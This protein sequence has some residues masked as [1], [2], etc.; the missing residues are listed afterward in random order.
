MHRKR[1]TV[2]TLALAAIFALP[3]GLAV[4][5]VA[6][7]DPTAI[8]QTIP[9]D[10]T[11][12]LVVRNLTELD[13]KIVAFSEKVGFPLGTPNSPFPRPLQ[14]IKDSMG[15]SEGIDD[16]GS[17]AI[18]VL[19]CTNA[20]STDE[21][22]GRLAVFIPTTDAKA[23]VDAL[24]G[25][26][27][28]DV[29]KLT[30]AGEPSVAA[31]ANNF[32]VV[33]Q[34]AETL[35]EALAVKG[36]VAQAMSPSRLDAYK[37]NDLT[38]WVNARGISQEIRQEVSTALMGVMAMGNPQL[39]GGAQ[40][41]NTVDQMNK[42]C[43]EASEF[44]AALTLDTQK[45]II[46][47]GYYALKPDSEY[48][49]QMA[50][51][52]TPQGPLLIGLPSEPTIVAFGSVGGGGNALYEK[53]MRQSFDQILNEQTL[54]AFVEAEKLQQIKD[55]LVNV[56]ISVETMSFG[57]S[58]LPAE[59]GQGMIGAT[60]VARVTNGEK[61]QTEVK[62]LFGLLK[63]VA[64]NAAKKSGD[65]EAEQIQT[66]EQAIQLKENAEQVPGA[67]VD[68]FAID[69]AKMPDMTPETLDQVKTVIGPEGVLIRSA[70]IGKNHVAITFG[71]GAERFAKIV[72]AVNANEAPL[73]SHP[74]VK[75]V[76]GRL[77]SDNQLMVA[78]VNVDHLFTF[79]MSIMNQTGQAMPF[80]IAIRNAAPVT[81]S[82]TKSGD[83]GQQFDLLLPTE[84][85]TSVGE[86]VQP[87]V[88]M[89]MMG[90]MGEDM[91]EP[92]S[93]PAAPD[94]SSGELK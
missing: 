71:G 39:A 8:L 20:K 31:S 62:K 91:G 73:A 26:K 93:E 60:L 87:F 56:L 30:L 42:F 59:A 47:T 40:L 54:G 1:R 70:A 78:Y 76:A 14:W 5:K 25:E 35:K 7:A 29:Y 32:L 17:L 49:R 77:P 45:G 92:G 11:A 89:M 9:K 66:V 68:H 72:A 82:V 3:A 12:V 37:A 27:E 6:A 23:L 44:A 4:E 53:Q 43:D 38:V 63:E 81:V 34:N 85:L 51:L 79:I 16:N 24:G 64:V 75:K 52:K 88:Q 86:V 33:A 2:F 94:D 19:D 58:G 83:A 57:L 41:Q 69:L 74:D 55:G 48:G 22:P 80:P 21:I 18:A 15:I 28:G 65:V 46:L 50:A 67:V 90:G 13:G 10:V 36:G 61:W 84:L